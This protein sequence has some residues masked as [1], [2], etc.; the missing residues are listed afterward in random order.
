MVKP[1]L[2]RLVPAAAERDSRPLAAP[3]ARPTLDAA[4]FNQLPLASASVGLMLYEFKF[5]V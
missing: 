3:A 2:V 4:M 1:T 5:F